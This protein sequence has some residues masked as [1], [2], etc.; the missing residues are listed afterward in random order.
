VKSK[1]YL[2]D[3]GYGHIV[4]QKAI[5]DSISSILDNEISF[6]IQTHNYLEVAK[7]VFTTGNFINKYNNISWAK[8]KDGSPDLEKINSYYKNY[9]LISNEYISNEENI[10]N[11]DFL[12]S[13]FV[14]EAFDLGLQKKI[15]T[16]G[17]AHFTWDW[18]FSKLYPPA[19]KNDLI[20]YFLKMSK[21]ASRIYFPPFT[22]KEILN[23]YKNAV[24]VPLIVRKKGFKKPITKNDNFKILIIDSGSGI[25]KSYIQKALKTVNKFND[26][27]FY[28]PDLYDID[29]DNIVKISFDQLLID[30]IDSV[31]L[32][33]SRAGF[34]TISECIACRTPMLLIGESM[35]PEIN[36]NIINL[37]LSGLA[38]FISLDNFKDSLHKFLPNFIKNEYKTLRYNMSNHE[39]KTN[40]AEVIA[41]DILNYIN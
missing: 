11:Y 1:I 8:L 37:K 22:P 15:P 6:T 39:M 12:I 40:G 29:F 18:F 41:K 27:T 9:K 32:V 26:I 10:S 34:N 36:E 7:T 20:D 14:Y 4:R 35:N 23:H 21:K 19:I 2:S 30:Y 33:I 31:D 17:V 24:N 5:S 25:L 38:S 3:E 28:V 16:F 13:D